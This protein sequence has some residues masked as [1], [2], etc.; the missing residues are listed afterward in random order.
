VN[1]PGVYALKTERKQ[2][3]MTRIALLLALITV[4]FAAT[5]TAGG[6]SFGLGIILGEPTGIGGKLNLSKRNAIDG[7]IAWSVE[8]DNDLHIHGDY[9]YHN[10]TVFNIQSGE[11]PLYF[12][13]GGRIRLREIHDDRVGIRFPV[14]LDYIFSTAPFDIF[15]E[16]VPILDLAPETDFDLNAA[17][18][19]RFFF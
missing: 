14:G 13:V 5:A 18:G 12:G 1:W 15:F 2:F 9:L 10:Y 17:I 3:A 6:G 11:L 4:L 8:E 16:I 7:A 19:G